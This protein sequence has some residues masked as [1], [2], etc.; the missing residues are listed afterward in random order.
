[1]TKCDKEFYTLEYAKG[2]I[3][4]I[5]AYIIL[6]G[7]ILSSLKI[8]KSEI[9]LTVPKTVFRTCQHSVKHKTIV[10]NNDLKGLFGKKMCSTVFY[11]VANKTKPS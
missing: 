3:A 8:E 6:H 10:D 9:P 11:A 1:L 5:Q 2:M 4:G 7:D